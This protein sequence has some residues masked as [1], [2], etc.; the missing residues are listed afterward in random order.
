[1]FSTSHTVSHG[2]DKLVCSLYSDNT[3]WF[4][5]YNP[6]AVSFHAASSVLLEDTSYKQGFC[7]RNSIG[8]SSLSESQR[9]CFPHLP[10]SMLLCCLTA[11]WLCSVY[12]T[13][14]NFLSLPVFGCKIITIAKFEP[15]LPYNTEPLLWSHGRTCS[16]SSFHTGHCSTWTVQKLQFVPGMVQVMFV[17]F[18][19]SRGVPKCWKGFL[20]YKLSYQAAQR[21]RSKERVHI[22]LNSKW[23]FSSITTHSTYLSELIIK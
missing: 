17:Y 16:H 10:P 15:F 9:F 20:K 3:C 13:L 21:N 6:S 7:S 14:K 11:E 2:I 1:M 12:N 4:V 5:W 8:L 23:Q 22:K 18:T 19:C